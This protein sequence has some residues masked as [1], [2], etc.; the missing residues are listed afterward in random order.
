M[1][2]NCTIRK[3]LHQDFL[4]AG[5]GYYA[6]IEH[7]DLVEPMS[8]LIGS[9]SGLEGL[10]HNRKIPVMVMMR[11]EEFSAPYGTWPV[12][13]QLVHRNWFR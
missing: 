1:R 10:P 11:Y 6:L 4:P 12:I 13:T 3:N 9:N 2:V 7:P 8:M 5:H